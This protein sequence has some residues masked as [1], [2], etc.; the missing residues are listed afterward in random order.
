MI[1]KKILKFIYHCFALLGM[2]SFIFGFFYVGKI[3]NDHNLSPRQLIVKAAK[4]TGLNSE[5]VQTAIAPG[6]KFEHHQLTGNFKSD[7]PRL[8][9]HSRDEIEKLRDRYLS[10]PKYKKMVDTY[11][12]GQADGFAIGTL[13]KEK[14]L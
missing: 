6:K 9:F 12:K 3:M 4:K 11:T 13:S 5:L 14:Q 7:H 2:A 10:D 8:I 1:I